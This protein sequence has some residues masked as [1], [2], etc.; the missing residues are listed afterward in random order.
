MHTTCMYISAVEAHLSVDLEGLNHP[1]VNEHTHRCKHG[2]VLIE[3]KIVKL[4][5]R[6][7]IVR[8]VRNWKLLYTQLKLG[9]KIAS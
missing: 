2:V 9:Y 3:R 1:T 7:F 8:G 6:K 5:T 4:E